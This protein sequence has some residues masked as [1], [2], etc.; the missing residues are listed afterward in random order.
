LSPPLISI[1]MPVYN[2]ECTVLQALR[3]IQNQSLP[4]WEL[5]IIDDGSKD[6]T[7]D[8]VNSVSDPRIRLYRD[9]VNRQLP[10]RLNQAISLARGR[11]FARMDG[12]DICFPRRLEIQMDY[13]R[14]HPETDLV[15]GSTLV[16]K[17]DGMIQSV[18][19]NQRDHASICGSRWS[20]FHLSHPTW[21]AETEWFWTH[22]YRPEATC[23]QDRDLLLRT[24]RQSRFA[25]V[26]EVVLGYRQDSV[27]LSKV[28]PMRLQFTK[29]LWQDRM[30]NGEVF[31]AAG[32]VISEISKLGVDLIA[33][34]TGLNYRRIRMMREPIPPQI[35]E[36]WK[37]LWSEVNA[38]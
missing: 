3:S 29:A 25:A 14:A 34:C 32:S 6:R 33:K 16:F 9:G 28:L 20:G 23:T 15:G 13:L 5:I 7:A 26:P 10:V 11:Y 37:E 30:A 35:C 31:T 19:H 18:A 27:P 21:L 1:G 12:D 8:V 36:E 22:P 17:S 4:S 24:H 38:A 2:C